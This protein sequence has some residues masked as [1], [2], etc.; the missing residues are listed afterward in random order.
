MAKASVEFSDWQETCRQHHTDRFPVNDEWRVARRGENLRLKIVCGEGQVVVRS[1]SLQRFYDGFME[2]VQFRA[3]SQG[4]VEMSFPAT[5]PLG[6]YTVVVRTA[7][8]AAPSDVGGA[9]GGEASAAKSSIESFDLPQRLLIVA[10]A[11][12]EDDEVYLSV[13]AE[14]EEYVLSSYGRVYA[15][16]KRGMPWS[17]GL[18]RESSV[19]AV[20]GLL[21]KCTDEDRSS[22]PRLCRRMTSLCNSADNNGVLEGNWSGDYSDGTKPW[23]WQGSAA[24]LEE[25]VN[26]GEQPV[27]F[28][29]C[30]V[31]SGL[32]TTVMRILGIPC[33]SV[34][35]FDSAH[36]TD[37]NRSIDSYFDEDGESLED[38]TADSIWNFHVWNDCWMKRRDLPP[39]YDG[40]Q[41]LD[42]TPQEESKAARERRSI[43]RMGPA[44]L[45]AVKQGLKCNYDTDFVIAEVNADI[46]E[47]VVKEG[48]DMELSSHKKG[49]VGSAVVTKQVGN[50]RVQYITDE[51]K[52]KEG[53]VAERATLLSTDS[54][55][56]DHGV[57][58]E[59][60]KPSWENLP[61]GAK[62]RLGVKMENKSDTSQK[63]S[64][65]FHARLCTYT[66]RVLKKLT[67]LSKSIQLA[68][69]GERE[70]ET[71][72]TPAQ[73]LNE[74]QD[75]V[76]M[77]FSVFAKIVSKESKTSAKTF[78]RTHSIMLE[79][80]EIRL[81]VAAEVG[82]GKM[83]S[84]QFEML[85][86]LRTNL[87]DITVSAECD[88]LLR[89]PLELSMGS[90]GAG[91]TLSGSFVIRGLEVGSHEL[92]VGVSCDQLTGIRTATDI[93]VVS[94]VTNTPV[95]S[96]TD[97][98]DI[99]D[100]DLKVPQNRISHH[101][102]DY[103]DDQV[104]ILRRGQPAIVEMEL[105]QDVKKVT[106]AARFTLK[107][108][109]GGRRTVITKLLQNVPVHDK[110]IDVS[111]SLDANMP[112]GRYSVILGVQT[113]SMHSA[114]LE[115]DDY[116][117]VLFNPWCSDDAVYLESEEELREYILNESGGIWVG[118]YR[119]NRPMKWDFGQFDMSSLETALFLIEKIPNK[120]RQDV[121]MVTRYLSSA[122]NSED[123]DGVLEGNW[124]GDYSGGTPP[125]DWIGSV[126]IF[127][128]YMNS[129]RTTRKKPVKYGQCFI[130]SGILTSALRTLGIPAR[131]VTNFRSAH[132][133]HFNRAIDYYLD[134]DGDPV[135]D[136]NGD[137]I[138]NF[139]V[140]N[141][142][143][144]KRPDLPYGFG[145]WQ[146]VDSTPQELSDEIFC[147]GP[148]PLKAVKMGNVVNYD[149]NFIIAEVNADHRLWVA[150]KAGDYTLKRVLAS[151]VGKEISTKALGSLERM[152]VTHLYKFEEG[153]IE[154]RAALGSNVAVGS[155]EG[156]DD[157]AAPSD[158]EFAIDAH[159]A[160]LG[161]DIRVDL[162]LK[163]TSEHQRT[164]HYRV[165]AS[166]L[167][168]TGRSQ[169]KPFYDTGMMQVTIPSHQG[170]STTVS[171]APSQYLGH[172]PPHQ[173]PWL[174]FVFF[175]RVEETDQCDVQTDTIELLL[176]E[177]KVE[178]ASSGGVNNEVRL[179]QPVELRISGDLS[180][181]AQ[182]R[183]IHGAVLSWHGRGLAKNQKKA[184]GPIDRSKPFS[185]VVSITPTLRGRHS[186]VVG[187]AS[188]ELVNVDGS[189]DLSV[190]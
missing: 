176:P 11:W 76:I 102:E 96:E 115:L 166:P 167:L 22:I 111:I 128:Q 75:R 146:A 33:R 159:E 189:L 24:I 87:T 14:R 78:T 70:V 8:S 17:F 15:G 56:D 164:F 173:Q 90:L 163:N 92:M 5:L 190:V 99:V 151:H 161:E 35:T 64:L 105:S 26:N 84:V 182:S 47:W 51:Y 79:P 117:T 184:L 12:N 121:H 107:K 181:G 125:T 142:A 9:A 186:L 48:E 41:A 109:V 29:Q 6:V 18:Y 140:W 34:T 153:S 7:F 67:P 134:A 71:V 69:D 4:E 85:N 147:C 172:L 31:F 45:H 137:S 187:L 127:E 171:I 23:I 135:E 145:G 108:R 91:E 180:I 112:V 110:K 185:E 116:V 68:K 177:L 104:L 162:G 118:K 72:I 37:F 114:S 122:L 21:A 123:N 143:W 36:D 174:K 82:Q 170:E 2:E 38:M 95:L 25:Y 183:P 43:F 62:V 28:G 39:G 139:H 74:F 55:S 148:A 13:E 10:N 89:R 54:E 40:W 80:P 83:A 131:S 61:V 106:F 81:R 150:N 133:T 77:T 124:S 46:R 165:T 101:T 60:L 130:F 175:G 16:S 100:V 59:V 57:T 65:R 156:K 73:Y 178:L 53:T 44:P 32:Y 86:P 154:E 188:P 30:W 27:K 152:D 3:L 157:S 93:D 120:F 42:A 136:L 58:F 126:Q 94:V 1:V 179:G 97:E 119:R 50:S 103:E 144:M 168:Y 66:G 138:W 49:G 20:S 52:Y 113:P 63:I 132:D 141:E 149:C 169:G 158:V 160:K 129:S 155:V 98:I 88:G 19:F